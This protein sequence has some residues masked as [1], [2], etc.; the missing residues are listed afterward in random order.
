[1]EVTFNAS[2]SSKVSP[3][4]WGNSFIISFFLDQLT[5]FFIVIKLN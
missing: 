4:N 5:I 1:M 2:F 3:L